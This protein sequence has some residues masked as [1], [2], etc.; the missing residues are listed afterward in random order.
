MKTNAARVLD[1]LKFKYEFA[2]ANMILKPGRSL[3]T[4]SGEACN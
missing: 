1:S 3:W 4:I 2:S